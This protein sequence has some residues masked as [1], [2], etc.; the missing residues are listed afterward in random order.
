MK[1]MIIREFGE[2]SVFT[3]VEI[4]QPEVKKGYVLIRVEASSVNPVDYK[5]RR[6]GPAISPELP[7][8]LHGDVA[9][10]VEA[11]G[12]GVSEFKV[13]DQIYGC[14]GGVKGHGGAIADYMLA[15]A[16]LIAKKPNSLDFASAAALPLVTIT[17]W[18]GLIDKANIQPGQTVL[19]HGGTG[20][21]GH[22]A[23]QLAK[24]RGA[25]VTATASTPEK[26][27]IAKELG[28]DEGVN[29]RDEAVSAYVNRL[30]HGEGFDLVFDSTGGDNLPHSFEAAKLNGTVV[31]PSSRQ[32]YDLSIM[33]AKGLSLHVVF[34]LLPM[35]KDLAR[36]RHGKILKAAA[37]L[38][39][40]GLLKPLI[41]TERF[42]FA[43]IGAA[44]DRLEENKAIGKI[45]LTHGF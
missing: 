42:S 5:I 29:Y 35:L 24:W 28:A 44:H 45:V 16:R 39:D 3:Q 43:Q 30:T 26:L 25:Q 32:A 19:V 27:Q 10:V 18:E 33:H 41:D 22:I 31:T 13:G 8:V 40:Q 6:Y 1:A 20:G 11:V 4:P 15:D 38:V 14:A 37:E 7:A 17:A 12:E 36:S 34:M 21:V 23:V 2:S 9:G